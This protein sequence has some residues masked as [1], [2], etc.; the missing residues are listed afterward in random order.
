MK[1]NELDYETQSGY[2]FNFDKFIEQT[3]EY[4]GRD[5]EAMADF[6][7]K[8]AKYYRDELEYE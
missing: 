1:F 6:L 4:C 8:Q 7:E 3:F 2:E 5:Y